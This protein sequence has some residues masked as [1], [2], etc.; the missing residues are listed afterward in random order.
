MALGVAVLNS[1][2]ASHGT[3]YRFCLTGVASG[4]RSTTMGA[5]FMAKPGVPSLPRHQGILLT[6]WGIYLFPSAENRDAIHL[7]GHDHGHHQS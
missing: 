5:G 6:G 4:L 2:A 1:Q 3:G 7:P